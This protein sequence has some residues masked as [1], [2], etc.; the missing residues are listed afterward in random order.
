MSPTHLTSE[1]VGRFEKF[2]IYGEPGT[3]KTFTAGT[4]PGPI[5]A[6]SVGNLNEIKTLLGPT[7]K[8]VMPDQQIY[9]DVAEESMGD[10]GVFDEAVGFDHVCD[11]LDEAVRLDKD[12][13]EDFSFETL[14]IDNA[15]VL[16]N[17]AMNKAMEVGYQTANSKSKTALAKLRK[18]NIVTPADNDWMSQMSLMG[19]F[20]NWLF[21]LK[22]H[23]VLI[24]HEWHETTTDRVSHTAKITSAKPL[25]TGKQRTEIPGLFDNVWRMDRN[26]QFFEART[27]ASSH[28]FPLTAKTRIGGVLDADYRNPNLSEAI[29]KLQAATKEDNA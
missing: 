14:I 29:A 21:R 27:E 19:Q 6:I 3:G 8:A 10:R 13:T 9:Y 1:V 23:V 15:T 20:V 17:Y 28:P 12:P 25:F 22:K 18:L 4:A 7:F 26:G 5:Y 16:G 2:L 11:L 24:A